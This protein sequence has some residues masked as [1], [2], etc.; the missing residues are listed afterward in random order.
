MSSSSSSSSSAAAA[1]ASSDVFFAPATGALSAC[2]LSATIELRD[3][4][5]L[6]H[7]AG[8]YPH[9]ASGVGDKGPLR[10]VM[11][12]VSGRVFVLADPGP[13]PGVDGQNFRIALENKG[14]QPI[15]YRLT[16]DGTPVET[17][18]TSKYVYLQGAADPVHAR[19]H[20]GYTAGASVISDGA[21]IKAFAFSLK[22]VYRA[23]E[24]GTAERL[25]ANLCL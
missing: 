4:K 18:N 12:P 8:E 20:V 21:V 1:G 19:T 10:V 17:A 15:G 7:T 3:A 23:D 9:D 14:A 13:R 6:W 16:I 25:S 11:H 24:G 22:E 5:G 2:G